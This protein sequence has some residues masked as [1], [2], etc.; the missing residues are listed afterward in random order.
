MLGPTV[1][2]TT[3]RLVVLADYKTAPTV[4]SAVRSHIVGSGKSTLRIHCDD[5]TVFDETDED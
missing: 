5:L 4:V 3:H 2:G 1:A